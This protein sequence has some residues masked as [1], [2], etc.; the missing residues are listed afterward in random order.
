[1][2]MVGDMASLGL[3]TLPLIGLVER[4]VRDTHLYE[5][6]SNPKDTPIPPVHETIAPSA[7][8]SQLTNLKIDVHPICHEL[9]KI[10]G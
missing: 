9:H 7:N 6:E 1:M 8:D 2:V 3:A 10:R 4:R 5:V